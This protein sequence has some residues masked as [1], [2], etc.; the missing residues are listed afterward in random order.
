[1]TNARVSYAP[2]QAGTRYPWLLLA[3]FAIVLAVLAID[4]ASR[5][6]WLLE[7]VLVAL[8]LPLLVWAY[9]RI[10]LSNA[11]YTLLFVFSVLH[12]IG[13]HYQYSE[14]PYEQ[15]FAAIS[16]GGSID[17]LFGFE[18][19]Q[20][21]RLLHFLYGVLVTPAVTEMICARV[22]LRGIWRY[23]L[24]A[25][26]MFSHGMVYELFEWIAAALFGGDL[27]TAYL[28]TQ[29]DAWD[30]QKDMALAVLGTV[31]ILPFWLR[32]LRRHPAA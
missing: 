19:N 18:R 8:A 4:P 23:M 17:A 16:G 10:R 2:A 26:F 11:A 22:D 21:D 32:R 6:D 3:A 15:W 30:A 31:L 24:P 9:R 5:S 27:G 14:V 29:G 12:E 25:T 13:A 28:G 1:M 20:Y 7:N